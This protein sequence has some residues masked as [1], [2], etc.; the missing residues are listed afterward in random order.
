[1]NTTALPATLQLAV[2]AAAIGHPD[3]AGGVEDRDELV[4]HA[5]R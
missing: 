5:G 4:G 3:E 1:V 2:D